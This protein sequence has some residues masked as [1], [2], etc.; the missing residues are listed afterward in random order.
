M[1]VEQPG[2]RKKRA[3]DKG[4]DTMHRPKF[5]MIPFYSFAI[6]EIVIMIC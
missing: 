1:D 4:G 6:A 2:I 3:E 5:M